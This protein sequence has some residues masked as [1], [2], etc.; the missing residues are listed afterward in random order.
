[1][2]S[3]RNRRRRGSAILH[4]PEDRL[5]HSGPGR[6][7]GAGGSRPRARRRPPVLPSPWFPQLLGAQV[8]GVYQNSP[9]FHSPYTGDKSFIF[10]HSFK[11][12]LTHVYGLYLGSQITPSLQ[13]YGDFE[14][15]R[16]SGISNGIGLGGFS[17]ADVIRAGPANLGQEPFLPASMPDTSSPYRMP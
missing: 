11:Q 13:A 5:V 14:M 6:P 10:D 8:N 7:G 12:Q 4:S 9:S 1:M 17:N 3:A 16:G 2:P 15:F